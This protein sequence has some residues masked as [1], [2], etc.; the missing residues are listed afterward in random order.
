[1]LTILIYF[2]LYF[3]DAK[4]LLSP[5]TGN[6]VSKSGLSLSQERN[7][8]TT[9]GVSVNSKPEK[10]GMNK[11]ISMSCICYN[12]SCI[13]ISGKRHKF[14]YGTSDNSETSS[15]SDHE[16]DTGYGD[17]LLSNPNKRNP[18]FSSSSIEGDNELTKQRNNTNE[19]SCKG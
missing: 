6:T 18:K 17:E 3:E 10:T 12:I 4:F 15:S 14:L 8:N 1:M 9:S 7:N 16:P 2:C 19:Y 13:Y 5:L 11:I